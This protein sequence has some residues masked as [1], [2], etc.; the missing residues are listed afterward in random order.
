[1]EKGI[2]ITRLRGREYAFFTASGLFSYKRIDNGTRLLVESMK[3]PEEGVFLDVGCGIGVI[4]IVAAHE[5]P[6]LVVVMSDVN[7]RATM[8]AG[9]NVEKMGL[10]N[11]E[12]V[13]GFLYEP[14]QERFFD[15]IVSNPP[16]SA[17]MK[18]V[19]KPLVM[20]APVHLTSGGSIQLVIQSNKGGKMLAR[21][22]DQAFGGHEVLAKGGGYRVFYSEKDKI[23]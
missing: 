18:K 11:A 5:N 22:I 7:P 15:T 3:I 13:T 12:V 6:D 2:I 21:Y 9:E 1:M 10:R 16:V 23:E 20:R 19:V 8:I 17:G 14:V 4:G